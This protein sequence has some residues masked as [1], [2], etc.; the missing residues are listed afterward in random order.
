MIEVIIGL[1]LI[2]NGIISI[3]ICGPANITHNIFG[4]S[5]TNLIWIGHF[6]RIIR[7][8]LGLTFIFF[9]NKIENYLLFI[10]LYLILDGVFSIIEARDFNSWDDFMRIILIGLGLYYLLRQLFY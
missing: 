6:F 10:G 1:F 5:T 4:I 3:I 8:L 2:F 7:I 9:Y